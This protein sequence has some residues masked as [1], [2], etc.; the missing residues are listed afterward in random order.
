MNTATCVGV[1][2]GARGVHELVTIQ[3]GNMMRLWL[4]ARCRDLC[5][6]RKLDPFKLNGEHIERSHSSESG[7]GKKP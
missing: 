2:C 3:G 7:K 6:E 1:E 4:C 5:L